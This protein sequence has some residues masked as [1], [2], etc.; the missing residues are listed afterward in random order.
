MRFVTLKPMR[1]NSDDLE[2]VSLSS[3]RL[4]GGKLYQDN[5]HRST[6]TLELAEQEP[7]VAIAACGRG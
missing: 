6:A 3:G 5:S 4:A 1:P 7:R 2:Q